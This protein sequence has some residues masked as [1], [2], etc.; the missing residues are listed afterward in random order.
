M[1]HRNA[2]LAIEGRLILVDRVRSGRPISHVAKEMGVSRQCVHRWVARFESEGRRGLEDRPSRPHRSPTRIP[3]P[4]ARTV[5][6]ARVEDRLG[7]AALAVKAGVSASTASRIVSRAGLPRLFDLD[8]VT[9]IQIR[10]SRRTELRYE[11]STPGSLIHVDVKKL[12]RI[13]EGGG[14]RGRGET[15]QNHIPTIERHRT[16]VGFDYVHAAVDD[17]SRLAYAEVRTDEKA[18]TCA[19]FLMNAAAFFRRNGV[20]VRQVMTDNAL[21]YA[22]SS[23]FRKA[24][25]T[26]RADHVL[27]RAHCPWQNGKV[28]RFNRTMQEEWAYRHPF[29]SN[30]ARAD[31]LA[32][33]LEHYNY[34]R[35]HTACGGQPPITRVS[36]TS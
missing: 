28:E 9:G 11:R 1:V 24:L 35:P 36:P 2:R 19:S 17:Y 23:S 4:V 22:T 3:D 10:A 16:R 13:P 25:I 26:I 14:W 29:T 6:E 34:A 30:T 18:D 32:P 33:F 7:P 12:G 31:A 15:R 21:A 5:L 27:I 20:I 8:P